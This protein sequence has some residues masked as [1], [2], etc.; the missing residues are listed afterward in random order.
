MWV[1]EQTAGSYGG[2]GEVKKALYTLGK[3]HCRERAGC[4]TIKGPPLPYVRFYRLY[5]HICPLFCLFCSTFFSSEG[6][7]RTIV[8]VTWTAMAII[9]PLDRLIAYKI[10]RLCSDIRKATQVLHAQDRAT[11]CRRRRHSDARLSLPFHFI[12]LF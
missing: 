6:D 3:E 11:T 12:L 5:N 4:S 10:R 8:L 1:L 2:G 7:S 9:L